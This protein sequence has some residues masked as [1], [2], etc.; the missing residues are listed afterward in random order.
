M[1]SFLSTR[2]IGRAVL[3]ILLQPLCFSCR[4]P[5]SSPTALCVP[6]WEKLDFI[7]EACRCCGLPLAVDMVLG[8]EPLCAE[9]SAL[10]SP[11]DQAVSAL[12]YNDA[13]RALLTPFKYAGRLQAVQLFAQLMLVQGK[14]L[15]AEVDWICPI[16]LHYKRQVRRRYNQSA[17][18]ARELAHLHG[19]PQKYSPHLLL[20][21][22]HNRPQA[23]LTRSARQENIKGVFAVTPL[24]QEKLA[25][26]HVLLID[27]VMTTGAT[28][29]EA[30]KILKKAGAQKVSV[31]T[32][33]RALH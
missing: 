15:L 19:C 25:D 10:S 12:L 29:K 30:A 14:H 11:I 26:C 16:P 32:L 23:G 9:C 13:S 27:D 6:C 31:L 24:W 18:I 3:N 20:R 8:L 7:G 2:Y 1:F 28:L 5:V 17:L 21:T 4:V 22:R 33:A